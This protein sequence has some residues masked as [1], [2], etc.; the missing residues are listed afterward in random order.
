MPWDEAMTD[1]VAA[2]AAARS[3]LGDTFTVDS[4][5][6]TYLF[7]FSPTGVRSFYALEEAVASKGIADWQMLRRKV[8]DELFSGRRTFPHEL[9]TRDDTARYLER[10]QWAIDVELTALGSSGTI[11]V[12]DFTRRLGHRV[13]LACWAGLEAAAPGPVFEH[14]REALDALDASD[15]FVRPER[16][17]EIAANGHRAERAALATAEAALIEAMARREAAGDTALPALVDQIIE[18]WSDVADPVERR[19]GIARDIVLVHLAS[20]SNLFAALGW[21]LVDLVTHRDASERVRV[22]DRDWTERCA[23]ES[24]RMAQRSVMMRYVL[25]PVDFDDGHHTYRI[26]P[27]VIVATLLPLTNLDS[28]PG[29]ERFDPDRWKG[30]RLAPDHGLE[31]RE[32]VTAFGHGSHTCPAQPFSLAAMVRTATAL[33]TQF[34]LAPR[35]EHARPLTGQIGG[36]ARSEHSCPVRY[37]RVEPVTS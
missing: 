1:P 20:M 15:A 4:G 21:M 12:F 27:G 8:P 9:F 33:V 32:L 26:P 19:T 28:A 34:E 36:V 25:Q 30:R 3:A 14:L 22:G 37:R 24:T 17:A 16:M 18:R 5:G 29:L 23:L 6:T 13:G 10:A 35:F 2:I 7:T 31:T 11:E